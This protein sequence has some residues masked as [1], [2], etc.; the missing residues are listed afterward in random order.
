M[1]T[2][3]YSEAFKNRNVIFEMYHIEVDFFSRVVH[4]I[5]CVCTKLE[6]IFRTGRQKKNSYLHKANAERKRG[7]EVKWKRARPLRML[8]GLQSH[9]QSLGPQGCDD[10]DDG[11]CFLHDG[12]GGGG[13]GR[14]R[15]WIGC[16]GGLGR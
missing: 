8:R 9:V 2:V 7:G 6:A 4:E 3:A 14:F 15:R 11:R 10:R 16:S 1:L 5:C 13:G 12:R